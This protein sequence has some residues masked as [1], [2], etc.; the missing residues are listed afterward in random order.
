MPAQIGFCS[1]GVLAYYAIAN[2]SS[3]TLALDEGRPA[4]I[5]PV[6]GRAGCLFLAFALPASSVISGAVVLAA[7]AAACAVGRTVTARRA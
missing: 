2:A 4:R 5:V 3:W 1:L 7:G 6:I